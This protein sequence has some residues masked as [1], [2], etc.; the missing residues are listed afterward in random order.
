MQA[1]PRIREVLAR[2]EETR[3]KY[4]NL[5]PASSEV[6]A[7]LVRVSRPQRV[8]EVGTSNGYSAII[9]GATVQPHGGTVM[10]I[11]RNADVA[12]EARAN[13]AAAG[14]QDI[15]TVLSGS[16]YK[17]LRDLPGPWDL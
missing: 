9:L 10:T 8:V 16:A 14:L 13:I 6:L 15:V 2:L 1:P 4:Y 11:E 12:E 17:I 7:L 3:W 5:H